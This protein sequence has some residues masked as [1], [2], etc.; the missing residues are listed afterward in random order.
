MLKFEV[1]VISYR[2]SVRHCHHRNRQFHYSCI[3]YGY[4]F[5]YYI[6]ICHLGRLFVKYVCYIHNYRPDQQKYLETT[7]H[8]NILRLITIPDTAVEPE[9]EVLVVSGARLDFAL[10][11]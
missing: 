10:N 11:G 4:I 2:N 9:S 1:D 3:L 7:T 6:E 8:C 5:C